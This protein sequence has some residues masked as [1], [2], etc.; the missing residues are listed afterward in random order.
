MSLSNAR[1]V[2]SQN[3]SGSKQSKVFHERPLLKSRDLDPCRV[4]SLRVMSS[5]ELLR[6]WVFVLSDHQPL[7]KQASGILSTAQLYEKKKNW[8]ENYQRYRKL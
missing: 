4:R 7:R 3:I 5:S 8:K 2:F 6:R 1:T